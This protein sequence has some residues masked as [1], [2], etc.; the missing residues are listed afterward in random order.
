MTKKKIKRII[1][2]VVV[3]AGVCTGGVFGVRQLLKSRSAA[4]EVTSVAGQNVA[5]WITFGED[6]G[7][8]GT[9]VS[10]VNQQVQ[11]PDDKIIKEVYVNEG[12]TVKIGD[13]LL[14][15]DTTLLELDK[16]LQELTV[17][18]I[19][20]EI[21]SAEADLKKLQNTTPV[22]KKAEDDDDDSGLLE[23]LGD[24]DDVARMA[25]S[26]EEVLMASAGGDE[27][28]QPET[29]PAE[30]TEQPQAQAQ[31]EVQQETTLQEETTSQEEQP[32]SES[33]NQQE[34]TTAGSEETGETSGTEELVVGGDE[35]Q[36]LTPD[37]L[38]EQN[39][40]SDLLSEEK[41]GEQDQGEKKAKMNQSLKKL[42]AYVR[43]RTM[44]D[45]GDVELV[46]TG[47]G[48][49]NM[50][51]ADVT[52]D[53]V[54]I[55]PHFAETADS[56]FEKQNTYMMLING[57]NVESEITGKVYG[58]A[59]INGESY[60]EIGGYT[61]VKEL[62]DEGQNVARLTI[63]FHE[64][65]DEEHEKA[66]EL[67]DIYL[68]IEAGVGN[69]NP[70]ELVFCLTGN[71]EDN[72]VVGT[73]GEKQ[74]PEPTTP[75]ESSEE[76]LVAENPDNENGDDG[77]AED[78][79]NEE[80]NNNSVQTEPS[81]EEDKN[82]ETVKAIQKVT[83]N[84]TWNDGT[85]APASCPQELALYIYEKE[86]S[87][88]PVKTIKLGG[89]MPETENPSDGGGGDDEPI[90][91]DESE[92][93]SA[94]DDGSLQESSGLTENDPPHQNQPRSWSITED[95]EINLD[96]LNSYRFEVKVDDRIPL[97]LYY[98]QSPANEKIEW[99]TSA[100]NPGTAVL[101]LTMNYQE[102]IESP[103]LRL[104][105]ISELTYE[106]GIKTEQGLAGGAYKGSGT[107]DDP[108]VFFVTDGVVIKNT[109]VNWVL[110]F[111]EEG[112]ERLKDEEGND[113]TGYYVRLEI[114]ESD[115][116]TGAFIRSIDLD[117]TI[118]VEYGFGPGT[119]WIF[120]S[121]TGITRYEEEEDDELPDDGFDGSGDAGWDSDIDGETYTAEEL[122]E[123]IKEK[124]REIRKLKLDERS[125]QLK[126]KKY[127]EEL[128]ESTVVSAVNGYVKSLG[129]NEGAG[130]PYMVV[131]SEGG[132]YLKTT[133]SELDLDSVKKGDVVTATSWE[134]NSTFEASIT[135]INYFP[136][137][138]SGDEFYYGSGNTNASNYPVLAHIE[139][140]GGLSAYE[141]VSVKFTVSSNSVDIYLPKAYIRS[142]NGQSYVYKRGSDGRLKKQY[143]HTAGIMSGY[144]GIKEGLSEDDYI[145]FPYG[146]N[147]KEG[148]KTKEESYEFF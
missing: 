101:N 73:G 5:E 138:T 56:H 33:E 6:E 89:T 139:D 125:A 82:T 23:G 147:V 40:V 50:V 99:E 81:S 27:V 134:T 114:R 8:S 107:K 71:S 137:S 53:T 67:E 93:E 49:R 58:T 110:G 66:A 90:P 32:A 78:L 52:A 45:E 15:Y 87:E 104:E 129:G 100:E 61:L 92:L 42:F 35:N 26:N 128:E 28:Q 135:Q 86:D 21:K 70:Q 83:V 94:G 121:D 24:D 72:V 108:Y 74:E 64:G 18:E 17:Q 123:A 109:F 106:N 68:E 120:S 2:A 38:G 131:S 65:L 12:D 25:G 75:D 1:I 11:V 88:E 13:K 60:P 124:E 133:V 43:I 116:I 14:S 20:L 122:A 84:V 103:L 148:A 113:I 7:T 47:D 136:S 143:V 36:V 80:N 140:P 98:L 55:V 102:P 145:A 31:E 95:W 130:E 146:K 117:G 44:P 59:K 127:V 57:L 91:E 69:L 37:E 4:V 19:Q 79:E 39:A 142:E 62:S 119:Y 51:L 54:R 46:D 97:A 10:D 141:S 96:D 76:E 30:A 48:Q 126:L 29:Q 77:A 41:D 112:T 144:V 63:A 132:L 34:E 9:V 22:A 111:N 85:N 118:R 105:P 16:E 115:T 3:T